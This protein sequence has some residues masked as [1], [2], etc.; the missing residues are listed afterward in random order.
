[1]KKQVLLFVMAILTFLCVGISSVSAAE[2]KFIIINKSNN[3]L[4][5]YENSQ[6]KK[7]FR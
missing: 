3:Q 6:L 7:Y 5:Y 2:S 4:A 1:M